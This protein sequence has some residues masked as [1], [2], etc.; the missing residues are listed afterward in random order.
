MTPD[1]KQYEILASVPKM[2]ATGILALVE[3]DASYRIGEFKNMTT[4]IRKMSNHEVD[5]ILIEDDLPH[6]PVQDLVVKAREIDPDIQIVVV[7]NSTPDQ[8]SGKLWMIGVDAYIFGRGT[9]TELAHR[10]A[11][12]LRLRWLS[13]QCDNLEKENKELWQLAVTDALTGLMNRGHFNERIE[14]ELARVQRYGGKLGCIMIDIDH[15]KLV[16]DNYGHL[17]GDHVLRHMGALL[18]NSLRSVDI[19]ARYGGEEF[20]AL[21]PETISNGL[22]IAAEKLRKAIESFNFREDLESDAECPD[23]ITVSIGLSSYPDPRVT[24]P[25]S[26][27]ELADKAMYKAKDGGRNQVQSA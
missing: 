20:I 24:S 7:M 5:L 6:L 14:K 26:M 1:Q 16:N 25:A 13:K 3:G 18:R 17:I 27:L 12:S 11:R 19:I 21:A 15:F 9:P 23:R 10:V 4:I 22:T 8:A 2:K